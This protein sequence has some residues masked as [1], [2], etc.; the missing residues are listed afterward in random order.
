MDLTPEETVLEGTWRWDG[1]T[2]VPSPEC[3]RIE[4]LVTSALRLV[5]KSPDGWDCLFRDPGD[6]RYWE[7]TYPESHLHGGGPPRLAVLTPAVAAEK[8]HLA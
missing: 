3:A 8:Y 6:E 1:V 2:V 5:A 4:A 7:L